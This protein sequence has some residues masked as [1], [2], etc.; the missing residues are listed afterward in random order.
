MGGRISVEDVEQV[1]T[2]PETR[3][4]A[5]PSCAHLRIGRTLHGQYLAVVTVGIAEL[6]P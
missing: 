5:I 2:D 6:E 3:I 4:R 1:F